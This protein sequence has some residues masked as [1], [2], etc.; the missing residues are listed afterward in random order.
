MPR[1][2]VVDRGWKSRTK[3]PPLGEEC[4]RAGLRVIR[5]W[6]NFRQ[7]AER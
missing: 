1:K 6:A 3:S 7:C 4:E 2:G 5:R